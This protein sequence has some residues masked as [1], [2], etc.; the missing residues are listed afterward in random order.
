M[1]IWEKGVKLEKIGRL[2][3]LNSQKLE[4]EAKDD[5]NKM[6]QIIY[7]KHALSFLKK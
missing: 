5:A 2:K 3:A 7:Y 1:K 4:S 6:Y